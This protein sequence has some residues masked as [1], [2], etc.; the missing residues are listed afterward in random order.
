[1]GGVQ[2]RMRAT[3]VR[4]MALRK[5][6]TQQAAATVLCGTACVL[7]GLHPIIHHLEGGTLDAI[8]DYLY[9]TSLNAMNHR[10]N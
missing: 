9:A 6:I 7:T 2:R 10:S 5:L 1:M 8:L 3:G 4:F